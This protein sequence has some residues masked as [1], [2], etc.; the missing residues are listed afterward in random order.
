MCNGIGQYEKE[1]RTLATHLR[2][3]WHNYDFEEKSLD[4]EKRVPRIDFINIDK[5]YFKVGK[6]EFVKESDCSKFIRKNDVKYYDKNYSFDIMTIVV[7]DHV[8]DFQ[9]DVSIVIDGKN[10]FLYNERL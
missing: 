6:A 7:D 8:K 10:V 9:L 1:A 5:V 3:T 2:S 4:A